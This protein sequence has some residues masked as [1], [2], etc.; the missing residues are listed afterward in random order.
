MKIITKLAMI[1]G[2]C[3]GLA[4]I[5]GGVFYFSSSYLNHAAAPHSCTGNHTNHTVIIKDGI[6][7]PSHI[8]TPQCDTLT[9]TNADT[10]DRLIAFGLHDRHEPYDGI[11]VQPLKTNQSFTVTLHQVGSFRFHDHIHDE[12]EGTFTVS[13]LNQ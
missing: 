11:T 6:A 3:A 9:I 13:P 5:T 8:D 7:T 12:V 4:A 2:V 1:F 10:E